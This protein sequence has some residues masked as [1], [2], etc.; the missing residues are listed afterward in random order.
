MTKSK[1]K[2]LLLIDKMKKTIGLLFALIFLYNCT[3]NTIYKKPAD[4]IPKDTMA[5][6]I[7]EMIVASSAK[8]IKTINLQRKINYFPFVYDRFKIDS[9][10]F[11][12]SSLYYTSRIDDYDEIL[13]RVKTTLE[14]EKEKYSTL[15]TIRDSI[16]R[17]SI[18]QINLKK[19]LLKDSIKEE[20]NLLKKSKQPRPK[21]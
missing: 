9:T 14:A 1:G 15:K 8:N 6:L 13:S 19:P 20:I 3:S 18:Q 5:I 7:H 2:E 4:L 16:T 12:E 17:D 10:R 11:K 21:M